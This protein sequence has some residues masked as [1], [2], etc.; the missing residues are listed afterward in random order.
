LFSPKLFYKDYIEGDR[1]ISTE[2][3]LIEGKLIHCLLFEP[4]NLKDKFNVVPGKTPSDNVRRVLKDMAQHT[5]VR[6]LD[7]VKD[8]VVLDSLKRM[9]LYQSL[10]ADDARIAKIKKKDHK[11]YWEFLCNPVVDVVDYDTLERCTNRVD[12][13]KSND[14]VMELLNRNETDFELDP[15]KTFSEEYIECS[16]NKYKFGLKGFIDHYVIND[17]DKTITII[18][19]KTTNKTLSDFAETVDY[20]RYWLQ[21]IIYCKLVFEKHKEQCNDYQILFKFIVIDKY[22]QV[23]PFSVTDDTMNKWGDALAKVLDTVDYHYKNK[24]YTLPYD[25]LVNDVAI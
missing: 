10:K 19:L 11:S 12:I 8:L 13:I 6:D 2:K 24:N 7:K 3:H 21:A 22:D 1:E 9:N 5:D 16:L 20:Y 4:E 18:D 15:I 17:E 23:Y 25:F 14:N